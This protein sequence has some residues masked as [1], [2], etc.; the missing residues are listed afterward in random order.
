MYVC[1]Y[2]ASSLSGHFHISCPNRTSSQPDIKSHHHFLC[3]SPLWQFCNVGSSL[4]MYIAS[5]KCAINSPLFHSVITVNSPQ[6][7]CSLSSQGQTPT[8]RSLFIPIAHSLLQTSSSA[9]TARYILT[10][11]FPSKCILLSCCCSVL[12]QK[13]KSQLLPG[14]SPG[15]L[16]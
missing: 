13:H 2:T 12:L 9:P 7:G 5:V 8:V 15:F 14:H 3:S 11:H 10:H 1:I 16:L 6:G 4:G